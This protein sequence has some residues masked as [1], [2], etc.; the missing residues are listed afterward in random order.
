[1]AAIINLWTQTPVTVKHSKTA[2]KSDVIIKKWIS[3]FKH[4]DKSLGM[5]NLVFKRVH[6][7][8]RL[9]K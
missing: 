9:Q 8:R 7:I 1:M 3:L 4:E 6:C 2:N 5:Q